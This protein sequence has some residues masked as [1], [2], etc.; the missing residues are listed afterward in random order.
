[1]G[2]WGGIKWINSHHHI[3]SSYVVM[4]QGVDHALKQGNV[5]N[6][7]KTQN[8]SPSTIIK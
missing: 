3:M 5:K 6:M 1:L 2:L 8:L 7:G 4:E